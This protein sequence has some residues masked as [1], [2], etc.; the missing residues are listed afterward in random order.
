MC[1][2]VNEKPSSSSAAA[3]RR[4]R[5]QSIITAIT[6]TVSSMIYIACSALN[7]TLHITLCGIRVVHTYIHIYTR[8]YIPMYSVGWKRVDSIHYAYIPLLDLSPSQPSKRTVCACERVSECLLFTIVCAFKSWKCVCVCV[9][10]MF[11]HRGTLLMTSSRRLFI[12]PF[13]YINVI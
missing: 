4:R 1:A 7:Y 11:D 10:N 13:L 5:R 12:W 8:I 2:H 3:A 9:A 6:A